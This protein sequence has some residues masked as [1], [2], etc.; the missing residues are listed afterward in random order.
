MKKESAVSRLRALDSEIVLLSHIQSTLE[1]VMETGLPAKGISERSEALSYISGI[2]HEKATSPELGEI[3]S[4]VSACELSDADKALLRIRKKVYQEES[5]TPSDLVN[6]LAAGKGKAH[7]AWVRA[8]EEN[9]WS[10][11]QPS[12]ENLVALCAMEQSTESTL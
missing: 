8:R 2:I 11:F 4:E 1:W 3:L 9:S 7:G 5:G 10:L 12:L 6:A